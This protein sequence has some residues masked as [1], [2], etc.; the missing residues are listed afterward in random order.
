MNKF[1]RNDDEPVWSL[2]VFSTKK[3]LYSSD[4][5]YTDN[6]FCWGAFA[7][8]KKENWVNEKKKIQDYF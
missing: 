4:F 5:I 6:M 7:P 8:S 2:F 3:I 1:H